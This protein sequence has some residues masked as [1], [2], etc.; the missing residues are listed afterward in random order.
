M[1]ITVWFKL[2]NVDTNNLKKGELDFDLC[3]FDPLRARSLKA[4]PEE[5]VRQ[6]WVAHLIDQ[7]GY[8]RECIVIEKQLT[9]LPHLLRTPHPLPRRRIDLLCYQRGGFEPP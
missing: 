9:D 2:S 6:R 7:L 4:T 3:L 1:D 8:P 5:Q